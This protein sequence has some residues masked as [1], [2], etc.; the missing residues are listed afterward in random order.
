MTSSDDHALVAALLGRQ[1]QGAFSVAVRRND[2]SPVVLKNHPI[3]DS[4]RPM[5]TLYWLIDKALV[6]EVSRLESRGTIDAIEADVDADEL[7][8]TH[9]TYEKERDALIPANHVGPTPS[10]GVGGTR[11]GVKCLHAHYGYYLVGGQ[12]P[13]G[14]W[15]HAQLR[16]AGV[17]YDP[18]R[19]AQ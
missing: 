4:G 17:A 8:A 12:D 13:V 5:P 7:A 19:T 10:G 6:K 3:L 1:P 9:A 14:E 18:S 16:D 2:K 11:K 15:V